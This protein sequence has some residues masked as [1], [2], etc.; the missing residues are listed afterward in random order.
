MQLILD[1]SDTKVTF[2]VDGIGNNNTD[3]YND[4]DYWM[5]ITASVKSR[6]FNYFH[7]DE[8]LEYQDLIMIR[9]NFRKLLFDQIGEKTELKFI[10][11]DFEFVLYPEKNLS[12]TYGTEDDISVDLIINLTDTDLAYNG[13]RYIYPLSKQDIKAWCEYLDEVIVT[14]NAKII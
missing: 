8:S 1:S 4:L 10:E 2:S 6:F 12:S 3:D 13:D 7:N 5:I 9:D 11:P 14:F